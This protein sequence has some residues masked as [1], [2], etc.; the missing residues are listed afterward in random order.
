MRSPDWIVPILLLLPPPS[1][2]PKTSSRQ[3]QRHTHATSNQQAVQ[4]SNSYNR[5]YCQHSKEAFSEAGS[6]G[7]NKTYPTRAGRPNSCLL[8]ARK[9]MQ[10][11]REEEGGGR[12]CAA[13][14]LIASTANVLTHWHTI[15]WWLQPPHPFA[16]RLLL[17]C[18]SR[19]K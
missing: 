15:A 8:S 12:R 13:P 16:H 4:F 11:G 18:H 17:L 14:T 19:H 5:A 1:S 7:S 6:P 9:M 10:E 2:T 3:R